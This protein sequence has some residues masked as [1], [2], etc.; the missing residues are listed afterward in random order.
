MVV[1][2][3]ELLAAPH[4]FRQ[5]AGVL[6]GLPEGDRLE[7]ASEIAFGD[8]VGKGLDEEPGAADGVDVEL[9]INLF[10]GK[11]GE[12]PEEQAANSFAGGTA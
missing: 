2:E 9:G 12:G 1:V 4:I 7:E 5:G 6:G 11:T 10:A 3:D 8:L